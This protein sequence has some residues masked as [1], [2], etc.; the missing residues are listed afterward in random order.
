LTA[1]IRHS[2][3]SL[4]VPNYRRYFAG[5][6][7]SLSGT[8][9]QTVAAVWVVLSLTGSGVAVGLTT[10]LQFLPMLLIGAWGGLL[11]DRI[12]KRRLLI[13]TQALMAIPA[14]GLFA[15]TATG[16]VAPWM[17]Y[18]AVFAMGAVNAIDNPTRQSFVI[19]MVGPD[20]V[21]NA[22]SLNSVIVQAARIVGPA[23]A[24]ILIATVGVVPCFALN[25]LTFVAMIL[26]LWR[27]DP[28]RLQAAPVAEPEPRAIRAGLRYVRQTPELMVPL[29]LM[30]L[31]GTLGFNFQV[32]LPLLAKFSFESGA[33]TYATLVSAM[34]VGSIAGALV[35]G[36][37]GR[38]GP[39]LI[40]GGALAFGVSALLSAAMP[41]L[42]LEVPML[43]L[44]GAAAVTFA[45]TINS[46]LQL[47]VSPEMRGRVMA[48]YSVVFLGSTPIGAP[49]TGWLA[50]SYDPRV[51]LLLA[52]IS[53][54]SAAWAA[55]ISF[56][57]IRDRHT[58]EST[59]AER[60][61]A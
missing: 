46:T 8:W 54:L 15:V 35:N 13:T 1:A 60:A 53:G 16:V 5:Q 43:M 4:E 42:A 7:V 31:V 26:A 52:G 33:M 27:M 55:H 56:A 47:A 2:F 50:Q 61:L 51:A 39:R 11:A 17:V 38:T 19:E 57:H 23:L 12:P 20:R 21:V 18:L 3:N 41:T 34:A 44:L 24:G 40:A 22:V 45:A 9:M 29:A 10:A 37:R 6:L 28:E 58:S 49:L 59:T 14:V 30:A 25:A 36:H 48:L 32:V